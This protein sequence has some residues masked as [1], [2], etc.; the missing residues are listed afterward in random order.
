[1]TS[2]AI[3]I[4]GLVKR[5]GDTLA[6]AGVGFDIAHAEMFGLIGPDG[7][8]KTTLIR[9]LS[10]LIDPD[11]GECRILD[12]PVMKEPA[13][14]RS[15]VGY[16]PQRFSL[17]QDLTVE[18]NLRFFADLFQVPK[19]ERLLRS[20]ELLEFSRLEPF[21]KRRAGQLSGG[22]K[23]KLALSCALIHTPEIL[24]LDEPTTGV[25]PVS[26]KEFWQIL[27]TLKNRGVTILLSTPY[28]DE[29]QQCDRVALM[30]KGNVLALGTSEEI[31]QR[32]PGTVY[33]VNGP[34]PTTLAAWFKKVLSPDQVRIL[35]DRIHVS[36]FENPQK[37]IDLLCRSATENG[38]IIDS[39]DITPAELEDAFVALIEKGGNGA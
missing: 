30:H 32:F 4:T 19:K 13:R 29:A 12:I 18:E 14:I 34:D 8:G 17:Y 33:A 37:T 26:R 31:T 39:A 35:G 7:A 28:M 6:L 21:V 9:I 1:M 23:Q 22:M 20:A 10:S 27:D 24:M 38:C 11:A 15:I 16:M 2:S 3:H 36:L 25:D 5:F